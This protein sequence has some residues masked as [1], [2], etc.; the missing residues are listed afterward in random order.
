MNR[1]ELENY[2]GKEH[3][4]TNKIKECARKLQCK[5]LIVTDGSYS[6]AVCS[7]TDMEHCS[8]VSYINVNKVQT[9]D[10]VGAGDYF[11]AQLI[12]NHKKD[13]MTATEIANEKTQ[14]WLE[15]KR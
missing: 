13:I 15:E 1:K 5:H 2:I 11:F 10:I 14:K 3:N 12:L 6:I 9:K 8:D 4:Y 7:M